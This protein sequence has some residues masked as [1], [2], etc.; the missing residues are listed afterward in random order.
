MSTNITTF[1]ATD[2]PAF[3]KSAETKNFFEGVSFGGGSY[4]VVSTKGKTWLLK[5]GEAEQVLMKPDAPDEP[6]AALEIVILDVGPSMDMRHNNRVFYLEKYEPGTSAKPD[7]AS[8]DGISPDA[9]V[10]HPQAKSC[11]LCPNNV[12]G[13]SATGKGKACASTKRMAIA[14]PDNLGE[15]M[16]LRVPSGSLLALNEYFGWMK[17]QGIKNPAHVV[18]KIGFDYSVEHAAFTFK[19]LGWALNDPTEAQEA[20][21]V[22][23]I[24]GKKQADAPAALPN[25][26]GEERPTFAA[27]VD[28]PKVAAEV[29]AEKAADEKP[30]PKTAKA[31]PAP[32]PAE[33][34]LPA[35]PKVKTEVKVEKASEPEPEVV[36]TDA[37]IDDVLDDLDFDA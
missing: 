30:A 27:P 31:K 24:T 21:V 5:D 35:E 37:D 2:V 9:G 23:Y 17:K 7:C 25:P 6:A 20:D 14:T 4:K 10:P 3:V 36:E 22:G 11:D 12:R 33:D 8:A 13:T 15:P 32:K 29:A 16:L 26:F 28:N 19:A 18:T 1:I 34:D